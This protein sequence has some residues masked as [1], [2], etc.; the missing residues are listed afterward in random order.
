MSG[1]QNKATL[2]EVRPNW[3]E[4]DNECCRSDDRHTS[5]CKRV[6]QAILL[7]EVYVFH[8]SHQLPNAS[9]QHEIS[10]EQPCNP[11]ILRRVRTKHVIEEQHNRSDQQITVCARQRAIC[12]VQ[13][14][15]T[16]GNVFNL[17]LIHISEPTRRTP[18]SYAVF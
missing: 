16:P 6:S 11:R 13:Q 7:V 17:S 1:L 5:W 14:A 8:K 10:N 4:Q 9:F 18:I 3:G 12:D 15:S 2:N